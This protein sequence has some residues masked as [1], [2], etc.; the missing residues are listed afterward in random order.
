[1][2]PRTVELMEEVAQRIEQEGTRAWFSF[3]QLKFLGAEAADY[4]KVT[5]TL[6]VLVLIPG[7]THWVCFTW[8]A[9]VRA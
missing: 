8:L 4:D 5:D 9:S 2:H 7:T 1:M 3:K 6:D